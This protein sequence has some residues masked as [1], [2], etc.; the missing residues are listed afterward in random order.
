MEQK[1]SYWN[2]ISRHDTKRVFSLKYWI[3]FLTNPCTRHICFGFFNDLFWISWQLFWDFSVK[4]FWQVQKVWS[5]PPPAGGY[6]PCTRHRHRAAPLLLNYGRWLFIGLA[7]FQKLSLDPY[8]LILWS[9]NTALLQPLQKRHWPITYHVR[10]TLVAWLVGEA[11]PTKYTECF[12]ILRT[13][14]YHE[15]TQKITMEDFHNDNV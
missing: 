6:N 15:K 12:N 10:L 4:V 11:V 14:L 1:Y 2:P 13:L 5:F 3:I 7:C 8:F 9:G